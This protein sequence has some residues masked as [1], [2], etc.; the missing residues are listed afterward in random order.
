MAAL[1]LLTWCLSFLLGFLI[2]SSNAFELS[3]E[4]ENARLDL[5]RSLICGSSCLMLPVFSSE[6]ASLF[7][8]VEAA[9]PGFT[10]SAIEG[11]YSSASL[12]NSSNSTDSC[13]PIAT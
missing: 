12:S 8:W 11:R 13:L 6:V 4:I 9:S 5:S 1:T 2:A 7:D 10:P 3:I